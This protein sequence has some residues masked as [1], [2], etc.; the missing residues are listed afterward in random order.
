MLL[1]DTT[2]ALVSRPGLVRFAKVNTRV[3]SAIGS[4]YQITALPTFLVFRDGQAEEKIGGS[5]YQK[6]REALKKIGRDVE[7]FEPVWRG[8]DF[9]RNY[10]DVTDQVEIP[11]CELLNVDSEGG[12]LRVLFSADKPSTLAGGKAAEK[13]V[14][15][16]REART[17]TTILRNKIRVKL[18]DG[19]Q[20]REYDGLSLK[21]DGT[22]HAYEVKT[23]NSSDPYQE[24]FDA[25]VSESN[26]A[27]GKLDGKE[28]KITSVEPPIRVPS[29]SSVVKGK[30]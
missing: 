29:V 12:G 30:Q 5:D 16:A 4:M 11:R 9:P 2:S 20:T 6:M 25:K 18:P 24:G 17:G 26:P 23:G 3:Q 27:I 14:L 7:I 8:A 19:P 21:P 10:V 22:Y 1:L 28:I 15:D 13:D